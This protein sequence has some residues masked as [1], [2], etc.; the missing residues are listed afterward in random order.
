LD[1]ALLAGIGVG[2]WRL[3]QDW[4]T[5]R[6]REQA[7]LHR[8]LQTTPPPRVSAS[9]R[10]GPVAATG[11]ADIALKMLFSKDRNPD[12]VVE[13]T[14]PPAPKPMPALPVLYGVMNVLDGTTAIMGE[15]PGAK[16]MGVRPGD[17]VG[18]FTLLAID[19]GEITLEWDGKAVTRNIEE[20]I[21]RRVPAPATPDVT[22]PRGPQ[23]APPVA[24]QPTQ[25]PGEPAPGKDIGSGVRACQP[26]DTS[27]AGTVADGHKKVVNPTPFGNMC[28]WVPI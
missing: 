8:R 26:G 23:P 9:L 28:Q 27:P 10:V 19:R 1:L 13:P 11:Y 3:R 16:S 18:E 20:M 25:K 17:Q 6:A 12:V 15:K 2:V 5:A 24:P 7:V 22:T 14:P 4:V 21:V